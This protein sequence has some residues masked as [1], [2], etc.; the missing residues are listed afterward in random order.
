LRK[1]LFALTLDNASSDLVAVN[2][3][4]DDLGENGNASLVCDEIFFRTS[5]DARAS[6]T[7]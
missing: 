7:F 4:I 3:I 6:G 1:K 2:D 5:G